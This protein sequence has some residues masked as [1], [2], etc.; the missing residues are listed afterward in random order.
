M[1]SVLK[2][3]M[4]TRASFSIYFTC[5][6]AGMKQ[7]RKQ[8]NVPGNTGSLSSILTHQCPILL[9]QTEDLAPRVLVP[10]GHDAVLQMKKVRDWFVVA[11]YIFTIDSQHFVFMRLT[12]PTA[13]KC[14]SVVDFWH[15][16]D[17]Y[18]YLGG[19]ITTKTDRISRV[20][21]KLKKHQGMVNT[22]V[23]S[24]CHQMK[25]VFFQKATVYKLYFSNSLHQP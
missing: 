15:P 7:M 4:I 14:S 5:I 25:H 10:P 12:Y 20:V 17:L 18:Y 24:K 19:S 22:S 9:Q 16:T 13:F 8:P 6:S 1:W 3:Y 23:F 21:N 2:L 11:G